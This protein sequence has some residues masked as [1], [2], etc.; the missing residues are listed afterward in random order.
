MMIAVY[1]LFLTKVKLDT[2]KI[3]NVFP[4]ILIM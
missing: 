4:V 2:E 3:N 1:N